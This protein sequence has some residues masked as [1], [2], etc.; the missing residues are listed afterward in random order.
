[1]QRLEQRRQDRLNRSFSDDEQE[2]RVRRLIRDDDSVSNSEESPDRVN[3]SLEG[4][5]S[6]FRRIPVTDRDIEEES[7]D[8]ESVGLLQG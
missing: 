1:M 2:R 7:L 4:E 3:Q 6:P 5:D 8:R